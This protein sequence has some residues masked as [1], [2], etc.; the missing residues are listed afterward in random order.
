MGTEAH[1]K[2]ISLENLLCKCNCKLATS[3]SQNN[4]YVLRN[5]FV[6]DGICIEG[7]SAKFTKSYYSM[8]LHLLVELSC[9]R[10]GF[11]L[12]SS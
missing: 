7:S 4:F 10:E 12:N 11:C 8:A 1:A 9:L 5:I 2:M 3:N 6:D